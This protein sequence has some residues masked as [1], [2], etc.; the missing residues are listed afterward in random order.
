MVVADEAALVE[1]ALDDVKQAAL[2]GIVLAILVLVLFLRSPGPTV[3]VATAV[4]VSL[5]GTLFLMHL[6]RAVR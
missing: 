6:R 2:I 1:D 4:P 5:L 3:V